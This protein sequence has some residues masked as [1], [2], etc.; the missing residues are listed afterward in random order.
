MCGAL[1]RHCVGQAVSA[2]SN[3][4]DEILL[5]EEVGFRFSACEDRF[6]RFDRNKNLSEPSDS[7]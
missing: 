4:H 3:A 2:P 5:C 1:F 7:D 6:Q